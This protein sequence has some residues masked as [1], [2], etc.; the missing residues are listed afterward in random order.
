MLKE[1]KILGHRGVSSIYPENTLLSF[2]KS[3]EGD[4]DGVELDVQLTKDGGLVIIHDEKLDRTTNGTG[5]VKDHTLE[6]IR[7]LDAGSFKN[8]KFKGEKI[9]T[10]N[11]VLELFKGTGKIINIELKNS[12]FRYPGMEEKVIKLIKEYGMENQVFITS[13]NHQSIIEFRKLT[14]EIQVGILLADIN[15][16]IEK[17]VEENN[18]EIIHPSIDYFNMCKDAFLRMKDKGKVISLYTV[19]DR[20]TIKELVELGINVITDYS[21]TKKD[22]F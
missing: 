5:Y 13:F 18:I 3:I 16:D 11:E 9:P 21:T 2:Q 7:K 20:R 12:I 19:N 8:E 15:I 22:L 1:F 14:K 4:M 6:E 17:Y 10:L